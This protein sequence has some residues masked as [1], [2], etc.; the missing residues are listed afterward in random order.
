MG[1]HVQCAV[2]TK[3]KGV[4]VWT[5]RASSPYL[6]SAVWPHALPSRSHANSLSVQAN[7][8]GEI[9][10]TK[11]AN[12]VMDSDADSQVNLLVDDARIHSACVGVL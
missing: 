10:N 12:I 8:A 9:G 2:G 4:C 3:H 6:G 7:E 11:V 1:T 5:Q